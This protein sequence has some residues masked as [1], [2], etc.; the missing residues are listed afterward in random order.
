MKWIDKK[1]IFTDV[2]DGEK[3]KVPYCKLVHRGQT[4][5]TVDWQA[6]DIHNPENSY[7]EIRYWSFYDPR[8]AVT[9]KYKLSEAKKEAERRIKKEIDFAVARSKHLPGYAKMNIREKRKATAY[10]LNIF[11]PKE[12]GQ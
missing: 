1:V 9:S 5:A 7:W 8:W 4:L 12:R 11:S 2:H 10:Y 3:V 6:K